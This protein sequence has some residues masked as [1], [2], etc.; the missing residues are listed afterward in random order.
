MDTAPI[1]SRCS[2]QTASQTT[3]Q[4]AP[5]QTASSQMSSK[6]SSHTNTITTTIQHHHRGKKTTTQQVQVSDQEMV[7]SVRT[8]GDIPAGGFVCELVGQYVMGASKMVH[9]SRQGK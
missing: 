5:S 6:S 2:L 9:V 8:I 4:I 1:S 7:W 3:S